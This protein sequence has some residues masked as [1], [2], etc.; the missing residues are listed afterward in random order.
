MALITRVHH[1]LNLHPQTHPFPFTKPTQKKH[2]ISCSSS[3][4]DELSLQLSTQ[5]KK[6]KTQKLQTQEAMKKSK[7]LLYTELCLF[8]GLSQDELKRK[9]E[10]M[11]EN[12]KLVLAQEFVKSDWAFNFHPLS[13]KSVKE[14]VDQ[15]LLHDNDGGMKDDN[16]SANNSI[17]FSGLKKLMGFSDD[18]K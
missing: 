11:E 13:V 10:K 2:Q 3:S 4:P 8:L 15:H 16:D 6:L 18:N 7:K 14:L 1:H 17:L 5:I 12:D 9:W